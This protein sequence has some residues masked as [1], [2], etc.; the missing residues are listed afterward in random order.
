MFLYIWQ[1]LAFIRCLYCWVKIQLVNLTQ[2]SGHCHWKRTLSRSLKLGC[3]ASAGSSQPTKTQGFSNMAEHLAR[4]HQWPGLHKFH[5][6]ASLDGHNHCMT[7]KLVTVFGNDYPRSLDFIFIVSNSLC[8][9]IR[10][11]STSSQSFIR[12]HPSF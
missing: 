4:C 10:L 6:L 12:G 2:Y 11:S 9:L 7:L 1:E 5:K 8:P 3:E